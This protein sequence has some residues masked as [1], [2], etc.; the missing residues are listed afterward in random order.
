M[1]G[2]TCRT[3]RSI[4]ALPPATVLFVLLCR[5]GGAAQSQAPASSAPNT[6]TNG[7][8]EHVLAPTAPP[9]GGTPYAPPPAPPPPPPP[10]PDAPRDER[11]AERLTAGADLERAQRELD[12]A[13]SDCE[14]ACRALASMERA[15]S[16]LCSLAEEP[17][18]Q[19]RCDA[20][21]VRLTAA[22]GRVRAAC[23]A[24]R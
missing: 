20:A 13:A 18:D 14:S 19:R 5:C 9:A 8:G 16:H 4:G 11:R 21:K 6:T 15:T 7:M 3:R 23:G 17:D 12:A 22:R 10:A 1:S 24:C 2:T